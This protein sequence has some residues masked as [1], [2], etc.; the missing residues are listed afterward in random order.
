[1]SD[2]VLE[3]KK[4]TKETENFRQVVFTG[5]HSQLVIMSLH[6]GEEIGE[7]VHRVDQILY[8]VKGEGEAVIEGKTNEF[9][10]GAAIVVP[11]GLRHNIRNT[12]DEPLKLFT[13]YS[14]PQHAPGTVQANKADAPMEQQ[15]PATMPS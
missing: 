8:M 15:Q 6:P 10:K 5:Q 9:E 4:M 12:G 1:M 11:S 13:I 3:L 14:P 7:E 2:Q